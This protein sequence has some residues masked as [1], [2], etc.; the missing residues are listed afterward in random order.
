MT[1]YLVII[2]M[3]GALAIWP[4]GRAALRA[5]W[6]TLRAQEVVAPPVPE[7]PPLRSFTFLSADEGDEVEERRR[8]LR[9]Q[10]RMAMNPPRTR[11]PR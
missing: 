5:F 8:A 3:L 7:S 4:R 9:A 11:R 10:S 1:G 6:T 2:A